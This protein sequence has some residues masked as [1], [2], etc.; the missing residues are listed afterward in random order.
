MM[1]CT[2]K[3]CIMQYGKVDPA[4]CEAVDYCPEATPP[5]TNS[6]Y[7]EREEAILAVDERIKQ[8]GYE[9]SPLVLSIRQSIRD[10]PSADVAPVV[11]GHWERQIRNDLGSKLNDIIICSN[12]SIAFSSE[13][14]VRRS[15]CPNCGAK[16]DIT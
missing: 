11:H 10:V 6:D 16:M 3:R 8:I 5:K 7:I 12:C 2:G 4:T 1:N 14:Q 13:N 15:Y 9:G